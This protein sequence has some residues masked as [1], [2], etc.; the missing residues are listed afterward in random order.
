MNLG[1]FQSVAQYYVGIL[2]ATILVIAA[3]AGIIGV[4]RLTYSMGQYQQLPDRIRR[5]S[6]VTRTPVTAI[7]VFGVVAC[8][9]MLPGKAA[10]LGTMYSFGAMLSFTIA[11]VALIGLRWRLAHDNMRELPGDVEVESE[12]AWYRAPGNLRLKS[13]DLP[14]FAVF[15]GIATAIAWLTVIV[16]Y[17]GR[18]E[19]KVAELGPG[20]DQHRRRRVHLA[21][22]RRH[23]LRPLSPGTRACR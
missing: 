12:E 5:I 15:G 8:L 3:N 7:V 18:P 11:H 9:V 14:L 4:S 19:G 10:F 2:A 22:A 17:V 21:G 13:F 20:A 16:F 23:H 1:A 6:P